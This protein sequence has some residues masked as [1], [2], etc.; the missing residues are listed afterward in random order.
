M[1]TD[2]DGTKVLLPFLLNSVTSY[3]SVT[4]LSKQEFDRHEY[5]RV[6][7]TDSDLKWVPG[8]D[9]YADQENAMIDHRG[10]VRCRDSTS[11]GPL[12]VINQITTSTCNDAVDFTANENFGAVLASHIN[13]SELHNS[14][15]RY[16]DIKSKKGK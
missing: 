9:T 2:D 16:G 13:V 6:H 3:I 15:T 5:P 11:R 1:A 8:S 7:L 14:T 12:T 10:N 4:S